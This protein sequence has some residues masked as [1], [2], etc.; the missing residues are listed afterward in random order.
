MRETTALL[1]IKNLRKH[2]GAVEVLKGVDLSLNKSEVVSIIGSSGSGK[3]TLLRC[4][5]LLEEFQQGDIILDGEII[6]YQSATGGERHR[7]KDRELSRQRSMTGMVF[8]SF[9]LFP[10]LDAAGNVML[11]L[12]KVRG[13]GKAEAREIAEKWLDR[14]GLL[15]RRDNFPSQLSGGQQQRVAIARA[16]AM[17]P[18]LVLLDEITSALDPELVQEVL[19]TVKSIADD[20][21]TLLLVTH[22]MRFARDVSSRVVFMEQ[23]RIVEDDTP[24]EI[25]NRPKN[26]RLASFLKSTRN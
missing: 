6:G 24:E 19:M 8:Q 10:H 21:A 16:L 22:E 17:N 20:G 23:G 13:M 2:Y 4:V 26:E 3:T 25:F 15:P 11:G 1:Q 5:N 7:L 14:V 9:N 12:R 18:K